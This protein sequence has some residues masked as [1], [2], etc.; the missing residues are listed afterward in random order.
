MSPLRSCLVLTSALL[1][2][3]LMPTPAAFGAGDPGSR[4][5]PEESAIVRWVDEYSPGAEALLTELANINSGTMNVAGVRKVGEVLAVEFS[6]IGLQSEWVELPAEMQRA[7]HLVV[8][9]QGN[10]G[11]K[12]LLI[13][14]LDTV[15]EADDDFQTATLEDRWLHGPGVEDMKGG[16][17]VMLYA[18]KALHAIGALE[19]RRFVAYFTG[20]EESPGTPLADTRE[21]LIEK[22]RWADVALGFEAGIRDAD[23]DYATVARR[24]ATEWIL[25]VEGRQAH[26]SGIFSD[27]VGSGAIFEAA[28]ILTAFHE[29]VR[30][31]QYLTFNPGSILGGTAVD[32]DFENTRGTVFGKTNVV[33]RRVVVH[34]G[35]RTISP[36]QLERAKAAMTAVVSRSLPNTSASIRFTEGYPPMAPT[37]G[38]VA[39]QGMLSDINIALGGE[40]MPALDPIRRGAADIS[41]VAPYTNALAGLGPFGEHGHSP[42]ERVD[43]DSMAPAIKR[44]AIL[45]YR[46][47]R[48]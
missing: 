2:A 15:F 6:K 17:V 14:H 19:D 26:S 39:L 45:I 24:G 33:S 27:E 11:Q 38:N 40:A 3:L 22:G 41:F 47:T 29:E 5:S 20:D 4:L 28:R 25:E 13:G 31:E 35:I 9:Q 48:E 37:D 8:S 44:A 34:G 10:K 1:P 46:L 42:E 43:L 12:L 21:D 32:Y 16:D 30:G 36:E 7:G 18:L 23:A